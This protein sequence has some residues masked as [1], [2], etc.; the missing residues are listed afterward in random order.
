MVSLL[1]FLQICHASHRGAGHIL[2]V[3]VQCAARGLERRSHPLGCAGGP[4]LVGDVEHLHHAGG[5]VDADDVAVLHQRD[6]PPHLRLGGHVAHHETVRAPR[7]PTVSEERAFIPEPRPHD[8]AGGCEH[9]RH[10]GAALGPLVADHDHGA[11]ELG[12]VLAQLGQHLLLRVE[13]EGGALEQQPLLAGDLSHGALRGEVAVQHLQM[14]RGLDGIAQRAQHVLPVRQGRASSQV[15]RHSLAS[16]RHAGAVDEALLHEVLE[17]GGGAADLV[18]VLHDVLAGGLEVC[19]E[20]NLVG[21]R[22]E[23]VQ[24]ELYARRVRHGDQV[25]HRVGGSAQRHHRH[26]R[27]LKR[28]ARH[29]VLGLEVELEEV[30]DSRACHTALVH[31]QR[32][33]RRDGAAVRQRHAQSLDGGGHG[34]G[35]VHA[36]AGARSGARVAHSVEARGLINLAR[37]KLAVALEGGHNVQC[38]AV[39]RVPRLD[40]ASVNHEGGSVKAGHSH[41]GTGHVLVAAGERD[42]TIVPL[43]A[44]HR[45]DTVSND[46]TRLK[47]EAHAVSAHG[48][49]VADSD[50]VETHAHHTSFLDA[51]LHLQSKVHEVHIARVALVPHRGDA[52]LSLVHVGLIHPRGVKHRLRGS[53]GLGLCNTRRVLVKLGLLRRHGL[54]HTGLTTDRAGPD[55]TLHRTDRTRLADV[56]L[57]AAKGD[58]THVD[59]CKGSHD[60]T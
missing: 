32:V 6:G 22:L 52:H 5:G 60:C 43:S 10:A 30:Q 27:V 13:A 44:H 51:L 12:G 8:G 37:D 46:V 41:Q 16:H 50:R 57:L 34:V 2:N 24:G 4:L 23:V 39:S 36:T 17:Y 56:D 3:L 53:L 35:S 55:E 14:A 54:D 1:M 58:P 21:A 15:L 29:D 40:G 49:T 48:N 42:V 38:A 45:L 47:A 20:G 28:R 7:E 31:L 19:D 33:L 9:L 59:R 18:D 11:L 26:H 25:Q